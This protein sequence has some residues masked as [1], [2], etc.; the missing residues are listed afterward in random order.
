M[1]SLILTVLNEGD[2]IRQLL[3]SIA[4]QT[5]SA[6][7]IVIV[8][9]GSS[10]DTVDIARSYAERLPLRLLVA[11]GCNISQ[12][13]NLAIAEA[14]GDIIAVT[15]AGV[16]LAADWLEAITA[17][18]LADASLSVAA[19]FFRADP[20]TRFEIALG[21][22]TLPLADEIDAGSFLPSSRSIAF[23]KRAALGI[24]GYPE[25]LDYCED[26]IFDLRLLLAGERFVFVP[27]ALAYF[28]PRANL[29][30]YFRQYYLYARGD[31]KADLWRARHS[32]R[33]ATYL[34]L[35]PGIGLAGWLAHPLLWLG[36]LLGGMVYLYRPYQ[37]LPFLMRAVDNRSLRTWLL[38]IAW[39][40]LLRLVG[41]V[42]KMLGYPRGWLWRLR[43]K[44]ANWKLPTLSQSVGE[45]S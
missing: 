21:A 42:A 40:P 44:P 20:Q 18:L 16:R 41:D 3:D 1:I 6:D 37:R 35:A 8:D 39:I 5:R 17:P 34:I 22:T 29:R 24:D 14:R 26:L 4:G 31:G 13:R 2:N 36:W 9:G 19:G 28:R 33:Y 30:S 15:D 32:L 38:C 27:G 23:R 12:G 11:A 25:W 43:H 45:G 7:E 10:D